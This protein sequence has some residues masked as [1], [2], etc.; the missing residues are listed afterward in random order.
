VQSRRRTREVQLLGN[1][2]EVAKVPQ[3]HGHRLDVGA[4]DRNRKRSRWRVS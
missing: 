2:H 1:G 3:F 4:A